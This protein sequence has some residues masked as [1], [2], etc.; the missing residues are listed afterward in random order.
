MFL[1]HR[2]T[3][4]D[5][6]RRKARSRRRMARRRRHHQR[7]RGLT[8]HSVCHGIRV[9]GEHRRLVETTDAR[10]RRQI[11]V[12]CE[13]RRLGIVPIG[14]SLPV[15]GSWFLFSEVLIHPFGFSHSKKLHNPTIAKRNTVCFLGHAQSHHLHI[16]P[17]HYLMK[18]DS[19]HAR[20]HTSSDGSWKKKTMKPPI[21]QQQSSSDILPCQ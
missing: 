14:N 19:A 18:K 9:I 7:R 10:R 16:L 4:S 13:G 15:V 20:A 1:Y 6:F 21:S 5:H 2:V 11:R 12:A 3:E 17:H 8:K